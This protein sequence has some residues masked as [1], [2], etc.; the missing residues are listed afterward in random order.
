MGNVCLVENIYSA[1]KPY[2]SRWR[3]NHPATPPPPKKGGL[4]M[5]EQWRTINGISMALNIPESTV[6]RYF[7]TFKEFFYSYG[8]DFGSRK[9]YPSSICNAVLKVYTTYQEGKTTVEI[10]TM[11]Q[12][13]FKQV[14]DVTDPQEALQTISSQKMYTLL[15]ELTQALMENTKIIKDLKEKQEIK[16]THWYQKIFKKHLI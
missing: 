13:D 12:N 7:S 4:Y 2:I 16:S 6:R 8:K 14:I 1:L 10:K 9:K 5:G 3:I 11:L 15:Q